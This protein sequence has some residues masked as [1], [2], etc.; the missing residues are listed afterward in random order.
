MI[1]DGLLERWEA[2]VAHSGDT[3]ALSH[4]LEYLSS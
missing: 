4:A 3:E 2:V 1:L